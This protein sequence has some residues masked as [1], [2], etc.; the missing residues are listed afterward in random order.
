VTISE[1][2]HADLVRTEDMEKLGMKAH[3]QDGTAFTQDEMLELRKQ[4]I[5]YES[6]CLKVSQLTIP[7]VIDNDVMPVIVE[8]A[9][10]KK[11]ENVFCN[12]GFNDVEMARSSY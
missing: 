6:G 8:M 12:R 11:T 7:E 9:E 3:K 4:F 5:F 10:V 1:T 2:L